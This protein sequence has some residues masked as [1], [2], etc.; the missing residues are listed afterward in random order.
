MCCTKSLVARAKPLPK[1]LSG[2]G[3]GTN[4]IRLSESMEPW[5]DASHSCQLQPMMLIPAIPMCYLIPHGDAG[6]PYEPNQSTPYWTQQEVPEVTTPGNK[7][8]ENGDRYSCDG[9]DEVYYHLL[10]G[11]EKPGTWHLVEESWLYAFSILSPLA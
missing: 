11:Y 5:R 4:S 2:S 9:D 6:S 1:D 3:P 7:A 10:E 8:P